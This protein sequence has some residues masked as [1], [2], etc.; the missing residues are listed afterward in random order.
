MT[1]YSTAMPRYLVDLHEQ[2][3]QWTATVP[4]FSGLILTARTRDR[5]IE[6]LPEYLRDELNSMRIDR[7]TLPVALTDPAALPAANQVLIEPKD[8][9]YSE[10][11]AEKLTDFAK[12]EYERTAVNAKLA[13]DRARANGALALAVIPVI[14]F[15]R[16]GEADQF[17]VIGT[18]IVVLGM[19]VLTLLAVWTRPAAGIGFTPEE[20]TTECDAIYNSRRTTRD[21]LY[22]IQ[23]AWTRGYVQLKQI[24]D[25]RFAYIRFQQA[26]LVLLTLLLG[27]LIWRTLLQ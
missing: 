25:G 18:L 2:D 3:G 7:K 21:T 26:G 4:G 23:D 17:L 15:L 16:P 24:A 13:E 1:E 11:A 20:L 9:E 27:I 5:L 22:L 14:A 6:Q 19:I 8:D 12:A 10:K